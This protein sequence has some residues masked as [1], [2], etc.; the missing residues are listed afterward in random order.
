MTRGHTLWVDVISWSADGSKIYSAASDDTDTEMIVWDVG[1]GKRIAGETH[2]LGR[3]T[4]IHELINEPTLFMLSYPK[5]GAFNDYPP[6]RISLLDES[7]NLDSDSSLISDYL[8]GVVPLDRTNQLVVYGMYQVQIL[9]A[10]LSPRMLLYEDRENRIVRVTASANE[11]FLAATSVSNVLTWD[12]KA[13]DSYTELSVLDN[14][15]LGPVAISNDGRYIAASRYSLASLPGPSPVYFWDREVGSGP[16]KRIEYQ[17]PVQ[18]VRMIETEP[19][20]VVLV[21]TGKDMLDCTVELYSPEGEL[22]KELYR[23]RKEIHS[24][25]ID[26]SH[27]RIVWVD[28]GSRAEM[29]SLANDEPQK[30]WKA[31]WPSTRNIQ[32]SPNDEQIAGQGF[33][34]DIFIFHSANGQQTRVLKGH[35]TSQIYIYLFGSVMLLLMVGVIS[36]HEERNKKHRKSGM[37][38]VGERLNW[39]MTQGEI[40]SSLPRFS[41]LEGKIDGHFEHILI[42]EGTHYP[43]MLGIFS[44]T[45]QSRENRVALKE[46]CIIFPHI[47]DTL[48]EMLIQPEFLFNSIAEWIGFQDIDLN[49][50]DALKKFSE[51]YTLRSPD[52]E[53]TKEV[54][55]DE[56]ARF[57]YENQG[58]TIE[59]KEDSVL[60]RWQ[61]VKSFTSSRFSS[62]DADSIISF[63][64]EAETIINL[65]LMRR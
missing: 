14:L 9:G 13:T 18:F 3:S 39:K 1:T 25:D 56:L 2:Q 37:I 49:E 45:E 7:L 38:N 53:R 10:D 63:K 62:D 48:P 51:A 28:S 40:P 44:W 36:R 61:R 41:F 29:W 22:V 65:L 19:E 64:E 46:L 34:E 23:D 21:V 15:E 43:I 31:T 30:M 55:H 60:M 20:P 17:Q 32:F 6:P 11:Q 42:G 27:H 54:I 12:M 57:L 8:G 35:H 33:I 24:I 16:V 52:L 58:W 50:S 4:W 59:I 5:N 26:Q 47:S